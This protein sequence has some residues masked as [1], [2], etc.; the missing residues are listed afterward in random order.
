MV[1]CFASDEARWTTGITLAIDGGASVG[2]T[3]SPE[4]PSEPLRH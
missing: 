1:F 2:Q 3:G 4:P